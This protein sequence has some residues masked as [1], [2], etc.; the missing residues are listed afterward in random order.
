MTCPLGCVPFW[1]AIA[2]VIA[3]WFMGLVVGYVVGRKS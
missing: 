3:A 2:V 1:L